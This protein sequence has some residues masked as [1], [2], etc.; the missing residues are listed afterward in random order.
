MGNITLVVKEEEE[1]V[2]DASNIC[3]QTNPV[4]LE[5]FGEYVAEMHTKNNQ[6]FVKQFQVN[7]VHNYMQLL[8]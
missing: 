7:S 3:M 8:S 1:E 4:K 5:E 2:E 6:G